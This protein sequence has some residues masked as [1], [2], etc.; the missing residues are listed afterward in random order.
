MKS[1]NNT[2]FTLIEVII[3]IALF[4]VLMGSAFVT[5]Y[6]LLQGSDVLNQKT[7]NQEEVNFVLHKINRA[8]N[9]IATINNPASGYSN[10][11]T[12]TKYDG[13]VVDIKLNANK[14][15]LRDG[16][17]GAYLPITTDNVKVTTLQFQYLPPVGTS[18]AGITAST[19]I[20]GFVA[21]TTKYIR[22]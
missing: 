2:G 18:P 7:I 11:L 22:N 6:Q 10:S 21:S 3:Y 4:T 16:I 19:T 17:S 9:S 14:I 1:K 20:N 13:T 8:L 5:A 15:E 12:I